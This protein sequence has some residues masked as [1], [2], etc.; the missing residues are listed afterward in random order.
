MAYP[1]L[2]RRVLN[3]SLGEEDPGLVDLARPVELQP[4]VAEAWLALSIA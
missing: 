4:D 1:N 3:V 2:Y